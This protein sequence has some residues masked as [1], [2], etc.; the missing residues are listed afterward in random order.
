M[1]SS[2]DHTTE[3]GT[4]WPHLDA[5]PLSTKMGTHVVYGHRG[6]LTHGTLDHPRTITNVIFIISLKPE[7]T[8]YLGQQNCSCN[9]ANFP[10]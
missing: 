2:M 5:K 8:V 9:T 7:L 6:E 1:K 4:P 3:T 10:T